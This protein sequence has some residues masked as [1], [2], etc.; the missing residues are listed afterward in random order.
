MGRLNIKEQTKR[1]LLI[2]SGNRCAFPMCDVE[3]INHKDQYIGNFCHIESAEELGER[4]NRMQTDEERRSYDN[5]IL[6]CANHHIITNDTKEYNVETLKK[7]K[8][9][10]EKR[11]CSTGV[12]VSQDE[13]DVIINKTYDETINY[14]KNLSTIKRYLLKFWE[15]NELT[16]EVM[17]L[18][19]FLKIFKKIPPSTRSFYAHILLLSSSLGH[20]SR[21]DSDIVKR[22]LG[23]SNEIEE[24]HYLILQSNKLLSKKLIDKE[25]FPPCEYRLFYTLGLS[26]IGLVLQCIRDYYKDND[27]EKEFIELVTELNFNLLDA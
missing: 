14:P 27:C 16:N 4:Y 17:K 20:W 7:M 23:L 25:V 8:R 18:K 6:L 3:L 13:I 24:K 10:H 21:I 15:E 9:E 5:L 26:D 11:I 1:K 19:I 2:L 12:D 22:E